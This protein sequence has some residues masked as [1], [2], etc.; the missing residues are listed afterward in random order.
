MV[1]EEKMRDWP[2]AAHKFG[3]FCLSVFVHQPLSMVYLSE[4]WEQRIWPGVRPQSFWMHSKCYHSAPMGISPRVTIVSLPKITLNIW[5]W[6]VVVVAPKGLGIKAMMRACF[7]IE[8][9]NFGTAHF[10]WTHTHKYIS[11]KCFIL[12][13]VLAG[14]KNVHLHKVLQQVQGL[15]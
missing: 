8:I 2:V 14:N 3:C 1:A 5:I 10:P 7:G 13:T 12:A 4:Q 6:L 11:W 9:A 15:K